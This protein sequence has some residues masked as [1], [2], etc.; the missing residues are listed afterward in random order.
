MGDIKLFVDTDGQPG[1][2]I[3]LAF[4]NVAG[5]GSTIIHDVSRT[6]NTYLFEEGH[7]IQ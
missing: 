1:L 3:V 6:S 5:S 7:T 4:V 2:E